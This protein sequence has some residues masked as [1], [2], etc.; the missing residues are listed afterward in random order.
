MKIKILKT[1]GFAFL[2]AFL[3]L[4]TAQAQTAATPET[5]AKNFYKWYLNNLN[6]DVFPRVHAKPALLKKVSARLGRWIYS[7]A[8]EEYGADYFLDAQDFDSN[9]ENNIEISKAAVKGN[10]ATVDVKLIS[11]PDSEGYSGERTLQ[12]KLLKE[13]GAWK[14]DR[15]TSK[16]N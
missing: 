2:L 10:A 4:G 16:G 11:P 9:W 1:F 14:I 8:Y 15:V 12:V 7:K 3:F 13:G 6:N 5:A